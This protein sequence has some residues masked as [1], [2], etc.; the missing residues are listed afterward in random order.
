MGL[1]N[2]VSPRTQVIVVVI[3]AMRYS[4]TV[5][6]MAPEESLVLDEN[7]FCLQFDSGLVEDDSG[8]RVAAHVERVQLP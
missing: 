6:L 4:L 2:M 3:G 7:V 5:L 1:F 8:R